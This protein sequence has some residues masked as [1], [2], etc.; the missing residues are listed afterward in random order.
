[1]KKVLSV[2]TCV[3]FALNAFFPAGTFLCACFG[4]HFTIIGVPAFAAVIAALSVCAAALA[5]IVP[6]TAKNEASLFR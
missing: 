3:L 6:I 1:M 4:S 5:L 2:L